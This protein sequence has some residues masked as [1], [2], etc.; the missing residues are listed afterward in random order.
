[1]LMYMLL[2]LTRNSE[3]GSSNTSARWSLPD[4][5]SPPEFPDKKAVLRRECIRKRRRG[6]TGYVKLTQNTETLKV[7]LERET[8]S[9]PLPGCT[10]A[11]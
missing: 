8:F 2:N 10:R 3:H 6:Q 9:P 4:K 1:M 11:T 5:K 7:K